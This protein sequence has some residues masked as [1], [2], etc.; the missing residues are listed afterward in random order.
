MQRAFPSVSVVKDLPCNTGGTGSVP[1]A[2]R[3]Q[4]SHAGKI[5]HVLEQLSPCTTTTE[6]LPQS[7]GP[8]AAEA[9]APRVHVPQ[10]E[11]PPQREAP[12]QRL[13]GSTHLP[14]LEQ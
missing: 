10:Q 7:L 1:G 14:Q 13:E 2:G 6:C 3:S 4:I 9:C 11:E 5:P 8:T 12:T